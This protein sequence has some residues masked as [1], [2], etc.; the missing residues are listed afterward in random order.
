M[1][2]WENFPQKLAAP[3]SGILPL[4]NA[5]NER[6]SIAG[7]DPLEPFTELKEFY[8]Y[9]ATILHTR[10]SYLIS[11]FVNHLDNDGNWQGKAE[12]PNWTETSIMAAIGEE[13]LAPPQ[14][15]HEL[16]AEWLLQQKKII[17]LLLW[18]KTTTFAIID[19]SGYFGSTWPNSYK[20]VTEAVNTAI[21]NKI[22]SQYFIGNYS[23]AS[24]LSNPDGT[25]Y[26][27]WI[28]TGQGKYEFSA[29]PG[30]TLNSAVDVY[31]LAGA[32][33]DFDGAGIV[34]EG[35]NLISSLPA[36]AYSSYT[37]PLIGNKNPI[38]VYPA[39]PF[40]ATGNTALGW[41]E[42]GGNFISKFN[43]PGGFEYV[44]ET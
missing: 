40:P 27:S 39:T 10:I 28:E 32:Y 36:G 29:I 2:S 26:G 20:T 7:Y 14:N 4:F 11:K 16:S 3:L 1:L 37:T 23:S 22:I 33:G 17:N 18:Y 24:P 25:K 15:L 34:V 6:S 41:S 12:I 9:G 38:P 30:D 13:R 43:V 21:A 31:F 42:R 5:V 44:E 8:K 35:M 19:S